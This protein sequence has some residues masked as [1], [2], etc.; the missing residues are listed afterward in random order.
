MRYSS[1]L[2]AAVLLLVPGGTRAQEPAP[3]APL[4]HTTF[5]EGQGDGGWK[6]FG[7]KAKVTTTKDATREGTSKDVLQFDYTI[8]KGELGV[9]TLAI[10]EN[11]IAAAHSLR[12]TLKADQT[13]T[14][15]AVMQE[16]NDG[17][18]YVALF[19]APADKWQTVTLAPSDFIRSDNPGDPQ[20]PNG[21]LDMDRVQYVAL[22]DLGQLFAQSDDPVVTALFNVKK[23]D[24]HFYLGDFE[25][26]RTPLPGASFAIK[27]DPRLDTFAY[28]QAGWLA[29]TGAQ[30]TTMSGKPLNGRGLQVTYHQEKGKIAGI[31]RPFPKGR[32]AGKDRLGLTLA[33]AKPTR[34]IVQ[35]EERGG[36]EGKYNTTVYVPGGAAAKDFSVPFKDFMAASDSKD[37][38]GKL[39]LENVYQ[40]LLLDPSGLLD[41]T[42]GDNTLWVGDLKATAD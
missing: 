4:I 26:G 11:E 27:S 1:L 8:G 20:D 29:L 31:V 3:A 14:L 13:T 22:T 41:Q 19:Y 21:Q 5:A 10:N 30:L 6:A 15:A 18:R 28:R 35:I 40:I 9:L 32:L 33:A 34:V 39:D 36:G 24:H 7:E 17:G 2:A 38:N 37:T 12:F 25:V 23:G 42:E 16:G